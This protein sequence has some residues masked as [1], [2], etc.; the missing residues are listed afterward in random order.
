MNLADLLVE[1]RDD[2][3]V[4]V[5]A[6]AGRLTRYEGIDDLVQGV[7]LRALERGGEFSYRGR[8]PFLAWMYLVA[9]RYLA[10]RHAHWSAL[11]R[12]PASL[13]RLTQAGDQATTGTGP[14]TYAARREM[15]TLAVRALAI[16]PPTDRRM[17]QW[18]S[19]GVS[20]K[21]R[22]ERLEMSYAAADSARRRALERFRKTYELL[23]SRA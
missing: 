22:A 13:V 4:F 18:E 1:Y 2:L 21:E 10:D 8:E 11:R 20:L 7:H 6:R 19:E 17:V 23:V 3:A 14:T 5:R 15:L 12:K 9:R 16:L